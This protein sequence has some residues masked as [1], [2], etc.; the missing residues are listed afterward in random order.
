M[1]RA[2]S[3]VLSG[4]WWS[5][6]DGTFDASQP[7]YFRP[8]GCRT[9]RIGVL[10][11][12][13]CFPPDEP[14]HLELKAEIEAAKAVRCPLHGERFSKLAPRIYRS[15]DFVE[16]MHLQPES[17]FASHSPQ[18]R[19]ALKAT[20]PPDRWPASEVTEPDGTVRFVLK[21]G[22]EIHR[23]GLS[24]WRGSIPRLLADRKARSLARSRV[25]PLG[26]RSYRRVL[27]GLLPN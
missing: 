23:I 2:V 9:Y 3:S 21:D 11:D 4:A 13:I 10:R 14:P 18:Y 20:L 17:W 27:C 5:K 16:P 24:V 25:I 22:T 1:R 8:V 26:R 12:C 7:E 19:K 15:L 6:D